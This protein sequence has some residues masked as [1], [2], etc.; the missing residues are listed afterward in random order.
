M[1]LKM[2]KEIKKNVIYIA[3]QDLLMDMELMHIKLII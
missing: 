1:L 2:N 3:K